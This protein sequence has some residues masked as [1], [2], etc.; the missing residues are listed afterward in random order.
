MA[1]P[2]EK[3]PALLIGI[4]YRENKNSPPPGLKWVKVK[5]GETLG[6]ISDDYGIRPL[7][8]M[9]YNWHT[10]NGFEVNYY[11]KHYVGCKDHNSRTYLFN[12]AENPGM[13]LVPDVPPAV[14]NG[15]AKVVDAVRNGKATSDSKLQVYIVEWL[16]NGS[17]IP[18]S[19]KWLYVFSGSGGADFGYLPG[20]GPPVPGRDEVPKAAGTEPFSAFTLDYPGSFHIAE[21]ADKLEYEIYISS[22]SAPTPALLSVVGAKENTK[23]NYEPGINWHF[24][25]DP[26]VLKKAASDGRQTR[27]THAYRGKASNGLVTVDLS[28]DR[29]YYF[30]LSPVQLG[31]TGIKAAMNNP[32]GMTRCLSPVS[33]RNFGILIVPMAPTSPNTWGQSPA[34]L[35]PDESD[36]R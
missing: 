13:I 21:K 32:D 12:G 11:L 25:S 18:V 27:T 22:E 9:L 4:S 26:T 30:L 14:A 20:L 2:K 29:R 19:G 3:K 1:D 8:L 31:P 17:S 33:R 5:K 16:A 23:P 35:R 28:K 6:S 7:D 10:V 24:L 15:P 34:T 36:S